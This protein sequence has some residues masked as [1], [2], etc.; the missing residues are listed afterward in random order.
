MRR[1]RRPP[2][3]AS[4]SPA[5]TDLPPPSRGDW[6]GLGACT[7]PYLTFP[8]LPL[9]EVLRLRATTTIEEEDV[10]FYGPRAR[11]A[12]VT[13]VGPLYTWFSVQGIVVHSGRPARHGPRL[14]RAQLDRA[15]PG[16]RRQLGRVV[17]PGVLG[18]LGTSLRA[19]FVSGPVHEARRQERAQVDPWP[20]VSSNIS[21]TSHVIL[22]SKNGHK[23]SQS[24]I[25]TITITQA[26]K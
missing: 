12:L 23:K 19:V 8:S 5:W 22:H 10:L 20:V 11:L 16:T 2:R 18:C 15:W 17:P 3:S 24:H 1:G 4:P 25:I 26:T 7:L 13:R 14:A 6:I 21:P 9:V